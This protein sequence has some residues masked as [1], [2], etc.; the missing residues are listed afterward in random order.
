MIVQSLYV[1]DL[2][3]RIVKV[4]VQS[5]Y[6]DDLISREKTIKD[7]FTLYHVTKNIIAKGGFNFRK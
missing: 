7:A 2:I 4:I 5:L 6:V 1:N 3:S